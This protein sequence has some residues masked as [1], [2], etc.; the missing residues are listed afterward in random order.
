MKKER[1]KKRKGHKVRRGI[2]WGCLGKA[3]WV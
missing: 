1:K 2:W 3:E